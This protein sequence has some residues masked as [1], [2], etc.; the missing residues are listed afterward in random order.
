MY[1]SW[2][3]KGKSL[4]RIN[5]NISDAESYYH[6]CKEQAENTYGSAQI[7][8]QGLS[9]IVTLYIVMEFILYIALTSH[10]ISYI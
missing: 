5:V 1:A 3:E 10:D 6:K 8:C 4:Y 2:Q 7:Q 9:S